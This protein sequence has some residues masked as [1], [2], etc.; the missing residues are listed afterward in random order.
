[1]LAILAVLTLLI[2]AIVLAMLQRRQERVKFAG[3]IAGGVAFLAW[4]LLFFSRSYLPVEFILQKW[5][6]ETLFQNPPAFYID[7]TSWVF[8]ISLLALGIETVFSRQG[9]K[10]FY[11]P[12]ILG[13][14][15]VGMLAI[16]AANPLTLLY[17]WTLLDT[18]TLLFLLTAPK[19]AY[20]RSQVVG[21]YA[22]RFLGSIF[23]AG[24]SIVE[25]SLTLPL[26]FTAISAPTNTYLLIAAVLRLGIWMP[27]RQGEKG[28]GEN[29]LLRAVLAAT[30]LHIVART[31][32]VG[33]L[34]SQRA[35]FL[36]FAIAAALFGGI[37]W[38][39]SS[40]KEPN[41]RA[42]FFGMGALSITAAILGYPAASIAWSVAFLLLGSLL[43]LAPHWSNPLTLLGALSFLGL[44][45]LPFTPT[46]VGSKI[47]FA[48]GW[49]V[50][51]GLAH[52]FLSGGYLKIIHVRNRNRAKHETWWDIFVLLGLIVGPVTTIVASFFI[53]GGTKNWALANGEWWGGAFAFGVVAA[54]MGLRYANLS[55]P[56]PITTA[57][58]ALGGLPRVFRKLANT[59]YRA[60]SD[61]IDLLTKIFEG[62]GG[63][64]WTFIGAVF[65]I[66]ILAST[67]GG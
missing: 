13:Y 66:V 38:L 34:I 15:G 3:I 43:F 46:W 47:Y 45:A 54:L 31:A 23:L 11:L 25:D 27:G 4:I 50:L 56:K 14:T 48:R 10:R 17:L 67:A 58:F 20:P 60:L 65:L 12:W 33:V 24:A 18:L 57:F 8:A 21:A 16:F 53:G 59:V 7:K 37:V 61:L 63:L 49:G 35:I 62:E 52:G 32:N 55:I 2:T 44:T 5:A 6:P 9:Q 28:K 41:L 42:W 29:F 1:M 30:S 51:L 64:I 22:T 40:E 26:T 36:S 19:E 39:F